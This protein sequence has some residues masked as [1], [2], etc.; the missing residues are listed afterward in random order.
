MI[1][2]IMKNYKDYK[3]MGARSKKG[4]NLNAKILT[5]IVHHKEKLT[6]TPEIK[7]ALRI[8]KS[9][10]SYHTTQLQDAGLIRK[11][12]T[13]G[14]AFWEPTNLGKSKGVQIS[15]QGVIAPHIGLHLI[16]FKFRLLEGTMPRLNKTSTLRGWIAHHGY[17]NGHRIQV[18]PKHIII[19]PIKK[20]ERIYSTD[21]FEA[22]QQARDKAIELAQIL[23][24]RHNLT[25]SKP[26]VCKGKKGCEGHYAIE[27][28]QLEGLN[29]STESGHS[30]SSPGLGELEPP[31]PEKAAG[32]MD[33]PR[34]VNEIKDLVQGSVRTQ[35]A[36]ANTQMLMAAGYKEMATAI[37]H[38]QKNA[39]VTSM[40]MRR[41]FKRLS[42]RSLGE[43]V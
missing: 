17:L 5:L 32:F 20:G 38:I 29:V 2:E 4:S 28:P 27:I 22:K 26:V 21:S 34:A 42:Q 12:F 15:T 30:D 16:A 25:L 40:F 33:M 31:T 37:H 1:G 24:E 41:I 18:T 11:V 23:I 10:L 9:K 3:G 13:E 35:N 43:F 39:K 36:L 8:S 6:P 19:W 14:C 7:S